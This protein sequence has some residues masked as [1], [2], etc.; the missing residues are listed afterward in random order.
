MTQSTLLKGGWDWNRYLF[1]HHSLTHSFGKQI[2]SVDHVSR[3]TKRNKAA[4]DLVREKGTVN[5]PSRIV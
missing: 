2:L 4:H 5:K 1:V 3:N